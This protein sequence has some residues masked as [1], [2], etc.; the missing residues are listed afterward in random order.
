MILI[1]IF[2]VWL[3]YWTIAIWTVSKCPANRQLIAFFC[4]LAVPVACEY[5]TRLWVVHQLADICHRS[6]EENHTNTLGD[7]ISSEFQ[8]GIV[9][10]NVKLP[11]SY[12]DDGAERSRAGAWH[13]QTV[14]KNYS[15]AAMSETN[16]YV[17]TQEGKLSCDNFATY[18]DC[19]SNFSREKSTIKVTTT[20]GI[21]YGSPSDLVRLR[22]QRVRLWTLRDSDVDVLSQWTE[23][24]ASKAE[25]WQFFWPLSKRRIHYCSTGGKSRTQWF[26]STINGDFGD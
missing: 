19:I 17:I 23:M 10:F 21:Q 8:G 24:V 15:L 11:E 20:G 7:D 4:F 16:D 5:S 14:L 9:H 6:T 22:Y 13:P 3:P 26:N 12:W 18:E 2:F 25:Y 1:A